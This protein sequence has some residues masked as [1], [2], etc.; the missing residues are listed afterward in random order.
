MLDYR[1]MLVFPNLADKVSLSGG[2][3]NTQKPLSNLKVRYISRYAESSSTTATIVGAF[4][5]TQRINFISLVGM[6]CSG[7]ATYTL[8]V[9]DAKGEAVTSIARQVWYPFGPS[10]A[11]IWEDPGFWTGMPD[12]EGLE[13]RSTWPL[14]AILPEAVECK[15]F[16]LTVTDACN[17]AGKLRFGR[18]FIGMG[19]QFSHNAEKFSL[20]NE[21]ETEVK[22]ARS[23]AEHFYRQE[24]YRVVRGDFEYLPFEEVTRKVDAWARRAGIDREVFIVTNPTRDNAMMQWSFMGRFKSLSSLEQQYYDLGNTGFEIKELLG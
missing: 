8:T 7:G 9:I 14:I 17:T 1:C 23:G 12:E 10:L 15:S 21:T 22:A 13:G 11:F 4:P 16:T 5:T 18:L 24:T 19:Y 6:N 20:T 3:W 2:S